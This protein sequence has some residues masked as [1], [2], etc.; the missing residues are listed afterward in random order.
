MQL[1]KP[2]FWDYKKP[3]LISWLL[4]PISKLV[5]VY[6]SF[7][8]NKKKNNFKIKTICIGNIYIGGTGKTSLAITINEILKKNKFRTCF[9]KKFYSN[10]DD[11]QKI[12][13]QNGRVF[14]EK[15]RFDSLKIAENEKYQYA[16][17]DDGLQDH[18]IDYDFKL[19]CFNTINWI[20]N[21]MVIPAGPLREN[22]K[23]LKQYNYVFLNGNLENLDF[24][25]KEIFSLNPK[26]QIMIGEYI[27][28]NLNEFNFN[29]N[30]LAFSGIGNHE[31]FIAMLKSNKFKIVKHIEYPDHYKYSKN[32]IKEL[33]KISKK[34]NCKII[35]TEK[36]FLRLEE[37]NINEIK[38]VKTKLK[39]VDE[40]KLIKAILNINEI[41]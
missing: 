5:E 22:I 37:E 8:L 13:Q 40:K 6:S 17:F 14:L 16:I 10:Q 4:F 7:F 1:K 11:E 28:T 39:I 41:H 15:K 9:I 34:L 33:L 32:D 29:E 35:T 24:I 23:N 25:K 3:N 38:F 19:V 26:I 20:G 31:T 12:L 30:Y 27:P 2:E 18:S 36:D 21:G